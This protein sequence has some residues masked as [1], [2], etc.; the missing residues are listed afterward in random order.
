MAIMTKKK[1]PEK[2]DHGPESGESAPSGKHPGGRPKGTV[3]ELRQQGRTRRL[4]IAVTPEQAASLER[5][6][7]QLKMAGRLPANYP[8]SHYLYDL[9]YPSSRK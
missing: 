5:E 9:I 8:L 7:L 2:S 1:A 3:G 6:L 4:Y